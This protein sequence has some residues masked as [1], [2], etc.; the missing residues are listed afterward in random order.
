MKEKNSFQKTGEILLP[1]LL[2]VVVG[3]AGRLFL[4]FLLNL[5]MTHFGEG[6]GSYMARHALIVQEIISGMSMLLGLFSISRIAGREIKAAEGSAIAR[7]TEKVNVYMIVCCMAVSASMGINMLFSLTGF[8]RRSEAYTKAA[9]NQFG[10]PFL[11][12]LLLFGIVSPLAEE[13]LFRGIIYNRMKK[14]YPCG[15]AIVISS[16]LFGAY[17]GNIVQGVYGTLMGFMLALVYEKSRSFMA[18]YLFHASANVSV[19]TVMYQ[20]KTREAMIHPAVCAVYL[21]VAAGLCIYFLQYSKRWKISHTDI[22]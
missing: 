13:V 15:L 9:E 7:V 22:N 16:L 17:H 4:F 5:T 6:Y 11:F 19:Y 3:D 1:F 12:G 8:D 18:P 21:A 14:Y 2:Y 10:I 20:V